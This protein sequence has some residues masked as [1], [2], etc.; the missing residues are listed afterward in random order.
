MGLKLLIADD[1]DSIRHGVSKYISMHTDIFDKIYE[2]AD[3]GQALDIIIGNQPEVLIIDVQMPIMN[4]LDVMK[5]AAQSNLHPLTIILSGYDEFSYAQKAMK[6]GAKEYL[7]KPVR[8]KE[9]LESIENI[10]NEAFGIGAK[11]EEDIVKKSPEEKTSGDR[12]ALMAHEYLV[13][14][15]REDIWQAGVAELLGI[16][17][18]YLSTAFVK[19]YGNS[20]SDELNKIRVERA[21]PYLL[22]TDMKTYEVAFKVGFKD[23]KYF[24][25]TFKKYTGQNPR[26]YRKSHMD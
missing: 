4:G 5:K 12:F 24:S 8:A 17:S 14:H 2:A 1:E 15:F 25:K 3:G 20:F 7:L 10:C 11:K 18:S 22:Q 13:E 19:K 23:E 16:S 26:E 6:L 21:C 9:I